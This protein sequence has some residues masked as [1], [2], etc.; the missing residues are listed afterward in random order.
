MNKL[1][2]DNLIAAVNSAVKEEVKYFGV[3]INTGLSDKEIIIN[4]IKSMVN[5][6]LMYYIKSYNENLELK[7]SS[8]INIVG[9]TFGNSFEE[10]QKNLLEK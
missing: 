3:A 8:G 10:I 1:T 6:K 4:T 7:S 9:Y 5:G 2:L